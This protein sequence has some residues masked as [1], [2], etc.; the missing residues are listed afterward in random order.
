MLGVSVIS[1][2]NHV[3]PSGPPWLKSRHQIRKKWPVTIFGRRFGFLQ[4]ISIQFERIKSLL[5]VPLWMCLYIFVTK[6][7]IVLLCSVQQVKTT[8]STDPRLR[9]HPAVSVPNYLLQPHIQTYEQLYLVPELWEKF[10][11]SS[12]KYKAVVEVGEQC[13][14]LALW[15]W[16]V[17]CR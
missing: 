12:L 5:C 10:H 2:Q 13:C 15:S 3:S 1:H 9:G 4:T 7:L 14:L 11:S 8:N 16:S 6:F 17:P